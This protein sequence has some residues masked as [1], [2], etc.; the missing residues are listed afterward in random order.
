M[1]PVYT[2]MNDETI[3]ECIELVIE[4]GVMVE[5]LH[6]VQPAMTVVVEGTR[7]YFARVDYL[8][9]CLTGTTLPFALRPHLH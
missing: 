6:D 3:S 2:Y 1:R 7:E 8:H 5:D 9:Y 4:H